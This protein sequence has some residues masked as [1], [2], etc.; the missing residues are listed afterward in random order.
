MG[1]YRDGP[2]FLEGVG[3][4][5]FGSFGKVQVFGEGGVVFGE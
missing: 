3:D 2:S 1:V 5:I 4:V